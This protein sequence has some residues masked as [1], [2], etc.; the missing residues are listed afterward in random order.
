MAITYQGSRTHTHTQTDARTTIR[1]MHQI[2]LLD[3]SR[4]SITQQKQSTTSISDIKTPPRCHRL[5]HRAEDREAGTRCAACSATAPKSI[6]LSA[7]NALHYRSTEQEENPVSGVQCLPQHK[8][9][10]HNRHNNTS[11]ALHLAFYEKKTLTFQSY[12]TITIT[13]IM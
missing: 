5:P 11:A 12:V 10:K 1:R 8:I 13:S 6:M 9:F 4:P 7:A 3:S 2:F